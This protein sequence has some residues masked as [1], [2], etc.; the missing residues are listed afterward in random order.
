LLHDSRESPRLVF[1]T[2]PA[3]RGRAYA[4]EA[5]LAVLRHG[6]GVLGLTRVFADVDEPNRASISVLEK[7][8]MKA[9]GR[10]IVAGRPLLFYEI[11]S[12]L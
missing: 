1:G 5:S 6:F 3:L 2:R 7:L 11:A 4:V 10:E 9:T 12:A 8:G